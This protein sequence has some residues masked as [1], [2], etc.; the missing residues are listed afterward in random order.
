MVTGQPLVG[1]RWDTLDGQW[2]RE[3]PTVS[4]VI[5]HYDQ[6]RQLDRTLASLAVQ[7][8]P[9]DLIEIIVVDDGTLLVPTVPAGVRL[10][11]QEDRGFRAAA[12][13]NL[14]ARQSS[15]AIICFLDAD[16]APE[17]QYVRESTRLPA[18][19]PDVVTVGHRRHADFS[20]SEAPDVSDAAKWALP[21]PQWLDDAYRGSRNLLD[22]DNRSYRYIISAVLT[23]SRAL[24]E[25]TGGF[26][27]TFQDYGG[28]DWEWAH[29]AWL[30]G[31]LLAHVPTAVAWHDGPD[32]GSREL[33][34][35]DKRA[36][37]NNE[38]LV[39]S[40]AIPLTG[41]RGRAVR[42][43]IADVVAVLDSAPSAAAA[44]IC[45]DSILAVL[46]H[47]T[48]VV[49]P[50]YG[51]VFAFD[52]RVLETGTPRANEVANKARVVIT[53]EAAVRVDSLQVDASVSTSDLLSAVERV[54]SGSEGAIVYENA[55]ASITIQASRAVARGARWGRDD[56]FTTSAIDAPWLTSLEN[57][58]RLGPYLGGWG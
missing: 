26:D 11:R 31:G 28:E 54:G 50:E 45:V 14:G 49:P 47:A 44:F 5:I 16:T 57:E 29:R 4:V 51:T 34:D 17:P 6:Q 22:S 37:K 20:S 21:S 46:P 27:E 52:D 38:M 32:W 58:P 19:A 25:E 2:P 40:R 13:R 23:C 43:P 12:A 24:F 9:R 55:G 41:S 53:L 33:D 7:D 42:G 15:G 10:V 1:N 48:C 18:L 35:P 56:L 39:L 8:Y 36:A 30:A 3:L